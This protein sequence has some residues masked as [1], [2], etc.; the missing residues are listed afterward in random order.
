ME[1]QLIFRMVDKRN[2]KGMYRFTVSR[3]SVWT[4]TYDGYVDDDDRHPHPY[5]DGI[6]VKVEKMHRFGFSSV[7]QMRGWCCDAEREVWL[8]SFEYAE[9]LVKVYKVVQPSK[10]YRGRRQT[11]FDKRAVKL[12]ACVPPGEFDRDPTLILKLQEEASKC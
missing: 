12:V 6:D 7:S 8:D 9:G 4:R 5:E 2:K 11:M 3:E 1:T 10:V